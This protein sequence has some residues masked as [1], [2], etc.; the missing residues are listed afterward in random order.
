MF[1]RWIR[2]NQSRHHTDNYPFGLPSTP[3][4][5]FIRKDKIDNSDRKL[6]IFIYGTLLFIYN[7]Y[8]NGFLFTVLK[9]IY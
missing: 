9:H 5:T 7:K 8:K 6:Y 3:Q 1:G 2:S 4:N